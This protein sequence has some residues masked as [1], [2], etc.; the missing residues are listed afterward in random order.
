MDIAKLYYPIFI[1]LLLLLTLVQINKYVNYSNK[2]LLL[3]RTV[4]DNISF[5]TCFLFVFVIGFRPLSGVFIDTMNYVNI[6]EKM[7]Y[8]DSVSDKGDFLFNS[9]MFYCSKFIT[10]SQFFLIVASVYFGAIYLACKKLFPKDVFFSFIINIAAFSFYTYATN[11]IR[12]GMAASVVT[13]AIAY[14]DNKKIMIPLFLIGV[15]LHASMALPVVSAVFAYYYSNTKTYLAFW[16]IC[17]LLSAFLGGSFESFFGGYIEDD[18][19]GYLMNTGGGED[20]GGKGGF[21][22]DFLIYGS[23]PILMG[24]FSVICKKYNNVYYKLVLNTY[25]ISNAF[26]ILVMRANFSNRFAY[27]SWF[28]YAIVLFYPLFHYPMWSQQYK[29]VGLIAFLHIAFTY[30]MWLIN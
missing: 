18:R 23:M 9:L 12:N 2:R 26:W 3:K 10:V 14:F 13:L 11:G 15:G 16:C 19:A 24:Y 5:F 17:I 22:L 28:L 4:N 8:A 21:R 27:L 20:Y 1:N 25:I 6:Y 30:F 7:K 29:K